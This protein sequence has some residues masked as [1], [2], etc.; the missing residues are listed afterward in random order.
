MTAAASSG[1]KKKSAKQS[2]ARRRAIRDRLAQRSLQSGV[3]KGHTFRN[4]AGQIA[5]YHALEKQIARTEDEK[6]R[7]ALLQRQE[8]LGG[9]EDYQNA[10]LTGAQYGETS[11]WLV[12]ELE[13]HRGRQHTRVLDVGAIAGT[14]Y[15]KYKS[16]DPVYIDLNPQADHV[17][18]AD[19]L[20]Y[21]VPDDSFDVVCLSL[22]INFV[23]DLSKRSEFAQY[24][25]AP[26]RRT[27]WLCAQHRCC[28][29]PTNL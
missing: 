10:S 4:H 25:Q 8:R 18:K 6:T 28:D 21:A 3:K 16:F 23:G 5:E 11:K 2:E 19:F 27:D 22:V 14:S 26:I 13:R 15:K 12:Q 9:L 24:P 20:D 1:S 7:A 29:V 17:E